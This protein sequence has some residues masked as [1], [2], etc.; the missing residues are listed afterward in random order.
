MHTLYI[1]W[2]FQKMGVRPLGTCICKGDVAGIRGT[3]A[4]QN[5]MFC[6]CHCD[7]LERPECHSLCCLHHCKQ[8]GEGQESC[9]EINVRTN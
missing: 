5:G 9:R 1:L 6:K 3:R 2:A 7:K 8:V 4:A